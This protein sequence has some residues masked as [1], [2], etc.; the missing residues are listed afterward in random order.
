M[1]SEFI[2]FLNLSIF[3][4]LVFYILYLLPQL[5][6]ILF[7]CRSYARTKY[8][9]CIIEFMFSVPM[10]Y[11]TIYNIE[12]LFVD[13]C[14]AQTRHQSLNRIQEQ[15]IESDEACL[16][17]FVPRPS[18]DIKISP[19]GLAMRVTVRSGLLCLALV[20]SCSLPDQWLQRQ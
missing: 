3:Q 10:N 18:S 1:A 7:H 8:L 20:V 2:D 15:A 16:L 4:R 9:V 17:V 12:S 5:L 11:I 19:W 6:R 14:W 13:H